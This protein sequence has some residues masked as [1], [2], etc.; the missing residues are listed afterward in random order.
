VSRGAGCGAAGLRLSNS[1]P[2][3]LQLK[4]SGLFVSSLIQELFHNLAGF[5]DEVGRW[6]LRVAKRGRALLFYGTSI[7]LLLH[8][9]A[10]PVPDPG[11]D[12]VNTYTLAPPDSRWD[13]VSA[14]AMDR[15]GTSPQYLRP[16]RTGRLP[17]TEAVSWT[18]RIVSGLFC[19][20]VK[21]DSAIAGQARSTRQ[22]GCHAACLLHANRTNRSHRGSRISVLFSTL[23]LHSL[24]I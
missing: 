15:N 3:L 2:S 16:V 20:P 4:Q 19:T 23:V 22:C 5:R 8:V 7:H 14:S 11:S 13:V 9:W 21:T 10:R 12:C 17:D 24:S 1:R 18:S 6:S